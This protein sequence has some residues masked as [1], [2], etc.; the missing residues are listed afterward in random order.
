MG[1]IHKIKLRLVG[2][3]NLLVYELEIPKSN[4]SVEESQGSQLLRKS[5]EKSKRH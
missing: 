1:T 3:E 5:F 2:G 4:V